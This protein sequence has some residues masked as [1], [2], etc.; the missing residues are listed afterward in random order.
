MIKITSALYTNEN[1]VSLTVFNSD[2]VVR[3]CSFDL[4]PL[5]HFRFC[6]DYGV[7]WFP[8][9]KATDAE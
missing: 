4:I 1:C 5:M 7:L 8:V 2:T 9:R 6:K 3:T